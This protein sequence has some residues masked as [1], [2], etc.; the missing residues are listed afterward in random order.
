MGKSC[1][2]I[3]DNRY[4]YI[5]DRKRLRREEKRREEPKPF[6]RN[7][8]G[9]WAHTFVFAWLSMV[10]ILFVWRRIVQNYSVFF[11]QGKLAKLASQRREQLTEGA[12]PS[13]EGGSTSTKPQ[14]PRAI[15]PRT[16]VLTKDLA[17]LTLPT[18]FR[19]RV[20][21]GLVF[22]CCRSIAI[23]LEISLF[24]FGNCF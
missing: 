21:F 20:C 12:K 15:S 23:I 24:S 17:K 16:N 7:D 5:S 11:F 13:T 9:C 10:C 14:P 19:I 6:L 18:S 2:S 4:G 8:C 3:I 22:S 1:I